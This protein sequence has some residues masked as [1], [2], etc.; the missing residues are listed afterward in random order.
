[1]FKKTSLCDGFPHRGV[2]CA[3]GNV[4]RGVLALNLTCVVSG[5]AGSVAVDPGGIVFYIF[6][7]DFFLCKFPYICSRQSQ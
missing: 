1:M 7:I 2:R 4:F 6:F 5:E 3:S